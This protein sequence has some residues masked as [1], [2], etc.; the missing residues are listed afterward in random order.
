MS[1][2]GKLLRVSA[3]QRSGLVAQR[4]RAALHFSSSTVTASHSSLGNRLSVLKM[5]T[6]DKVTAKISADPTQGTWLGVPALAPEGPTT[7][8]FGESCVFSF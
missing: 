3:T 5:R 2:E 8:N 7:N 1:E 6:E 4:G